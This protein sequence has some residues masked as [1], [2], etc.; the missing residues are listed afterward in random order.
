MIF[1]WKIDGSHLMAAFSPA[2][3]SAHPDEKSRWSIPLRS[4]LVT[5]NSTFGRAILLPRVNFPSMWLQA[6][7]FKPTDTSAPSFSLGCSKWQDYNRQ[8]PKA[9]LFSD[10]KLIN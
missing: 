8:V 6:V 7:H 2:P 1:F 5:S 10:I 4:G 3:A 9:H